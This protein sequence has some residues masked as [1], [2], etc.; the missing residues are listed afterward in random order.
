[1][2]SLET[3]ELYSVRALIR[4]LRDA[5]NGVANSERSM[6]TRFVVIAREDRFV[7]GKLA[8][9]NTRNQQAMADLEKQM[10]FILGEVDL[11]V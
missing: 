1:M 11:R 2:P 9:E 8:G 6:T 3:G 10:A 4:N 5:T 7:I